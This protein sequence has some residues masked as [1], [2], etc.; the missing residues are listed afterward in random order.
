ML[1]TTIHRIDADDQITFLDDGFRRQA[2]DAGVPDLPAEV[3]GKNLFLYMAGQLTHIWYHLLVERARQGVEITFP[4][5]C[6]SPVL[7]RELQ[8]VMRPLKDNGV[9]FESYPIVEAPRAFTP[10]LDPTIAR[11]LET[12]T[13]CAWC[14]QLRSVI[15]W[16]EVEQAVT[17][18][19]AF[20]EPFP[21]T[22]DY[23]ICSA[24]ENR[25]K[26]LL[27]GTMDR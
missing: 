8:M 7:R 24:D 12:V 4:F 15:G 22:I 18:L 11:S 25:L 5:R 2:E 16:L 1:P 14:K 9:E 23:G 19:Q 27:S 10:L 26:A 17:I 3:M 13:M 21:P 6:D 20:T